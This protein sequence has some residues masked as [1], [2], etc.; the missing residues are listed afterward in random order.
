MI[1]LLWI[2]IFFLPIYTFSQVRL[3]YTEEAIREEFYDNKTYDKAYKDDYYY[4]SY[5]FGDDDVLALYYFKYDQ[6]GCYSTIVAPR[7]QGTLNT[8]VERYNR[9]YVIISSTEWMMYHD[10]GIARIR[11]IY[12]DENVFFVW[13]LEY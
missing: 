6:K 8:L 13:Y 1:R 10:E 12:E 7:T 4:I 3:G 5:D 2:I 9:Q 11:L